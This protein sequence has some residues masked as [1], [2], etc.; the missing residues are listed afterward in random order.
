MDIERLRRNWENMGRKDPMWAILTQRGKEGGGWDE[1]EFFRTGEADIAWLGSW[2][3]LH[4]IPV[5]EGDALDFGCGIG[6]LTRALAPHFRSVTGVDIS[7]SMIELARQKNRHGERVRYACNTRADLA[8]FA[9]GTF[10]FVNSMQVLQHMRP[11]YALNYVREFLRVLRPGGLLFFQ[12]PTSELRAAPARMAPAI[13]PPEEAHMEMYVTP[14][15]RVLGVLA[16]GG[17]TVLQQEEDRM[18]GQ[19]WRSFHLA[20]AKGEGVRQQA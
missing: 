15:D 11:E 20:V 13:E 10:A 5:P 14:L 6:R 7:A 9:T 3:G 18:A 8:Q 2:L 19:H 17:G 4:R 16:E 12:I 1:G